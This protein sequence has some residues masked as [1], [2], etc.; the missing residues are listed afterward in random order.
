MCSSINNTAVADGSW[1]A[2]KLSLEKVQ[3]LS[4]AHIGVTSIIKKTIN[5]NQPSCSFNLSNNIWWG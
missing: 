2:C 3:R 1:A 4:K 5:S